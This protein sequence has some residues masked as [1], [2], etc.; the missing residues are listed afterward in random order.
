MKSMFG[1]SVAHDDNILRPFRAYVYY[2]GRCP[3]LAYYT[4]SGLLHNSPE[5]AKYNSEAVTAPRIHQRG[6]NAPRI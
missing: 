6:G 5:R 3:M 1:I 4:L 2:I